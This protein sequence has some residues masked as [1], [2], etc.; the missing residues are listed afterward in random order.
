M[1]VLMQEDGNLASQYG[2][3]AA[4]HNALVDYVKKLK[5]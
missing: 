1:G 4:A 3:C 5:R 2:R